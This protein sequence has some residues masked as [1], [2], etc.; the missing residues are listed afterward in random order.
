MEEKSIEASLIALPFG[1]A[2]ERE[3]DVARGHLAEADFGA[4]NGVLVVGDRDKP[5]N[6]R[7]IEKMRNDFY[8]SRNILCVRKKIKGLPEHK[9]GLEIGMGILELDHQLSIAHSKPKQLVLEL[10]DDPDFN[11]VPSSMLDVISD[12]HILGVPFGLIAIDRDTG[13]LFGVDDVQK[14]V[15]GNV[16]TSSSSNV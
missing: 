4:A 6:R 3:P 15:H 11:N 2:S 1:S 8:S 14:G 5:A 16:T 7:I 12:G 13:Q 10:D 9:M